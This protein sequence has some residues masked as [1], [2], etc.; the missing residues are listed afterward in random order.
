[1]STNKKINVGQLGDINVLP[2]LSLEFSEV[3]ILGFE[4]ARLGV[5]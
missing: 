4:I 1:M 3:N 2:K 5:D